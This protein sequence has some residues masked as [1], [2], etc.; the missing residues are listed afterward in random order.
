MVMREEINGRVARLQQG[1]VEQGLDGALLIQPLDIFYYSGTRQNGVLW[2]PTQG[3]SQLLVRKSLARAQEEGTAGLIRPFPSSKEFPT[4][5]PE[6]VQRVGMTF[7]VVPVQQH[8]Y[9][10]K[11]L[12]SR[13]FVD[14]SLLNRTIRSIK[15]ASELER[16]HVAG[17]L[18]CG[19]FAAVPDFLQAGMS[20]LELA[21]EFEY[22]L[23]KAGGEGYVRMRAFNQELALGLAL[24][25]DSA[26]CPGFFDGAVTGPGLSSASPQG[27]S[28]AA[29]ARDVPVFVDYTGVFDGYIVDMTRLFV[30]GEL[31]AEL[32]KAFVVACEIQAWLV[33][34]LLPGT[35]CEELFAGAAALA[36]ASG[37]G[38]HFMGAP[39]E[40]AKFV[41]HGVG[42]ELD[43]LPVLAQGFKLPLVAGQVIAIE[44]KFVFPGR[45]VVG[46]ENTFVVSTGGGIKITDLDDA[47][48]SL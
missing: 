1:L 2:V 7:D 47:I 12:G 40:N 18:L 16:L 19:V 28:R 24:A 34:R 32:Q 10:G 46:I 11:L 8:Q 39:G 26:A 25:G 37:F 13:E 23:R 27:A 20:E 42:L 41:G 30:C 45:G 9:Y 38:R 35:I 14:I 4:L 31:D 6:D 21:A 43:E 44:P 36:E 5:F 15:S 17:A 48:V 22:R 3:T 29:I 33:A